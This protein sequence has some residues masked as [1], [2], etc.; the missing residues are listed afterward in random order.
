[1]ARL[2]V[3]YARVPDGN[4]HPYRLRFHLD[5][6]NATSTLDFAVSVGLTGTA[7]MY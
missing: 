6:T 2:V 7:W 1:M 4:P 5:T 3:P